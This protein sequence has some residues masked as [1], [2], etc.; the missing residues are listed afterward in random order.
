M[1]YKIELLYFSGW[2][3]A[4]WTKERDG[5]T[6][7]LHFHTAD[8]AQSALGDFFADVKWAVAGGN[9]DTDESAADYRIAFV[10]D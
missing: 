2:A 10:S 7:P 1:P 4:E 3:D 9:M 6:E 8:E 5:H